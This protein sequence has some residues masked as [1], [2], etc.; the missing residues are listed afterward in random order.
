MPKVT[1][2]PGDGIGPEI[3]QVLL[4]VVEALDI[5]IEW[6]IFDAGHKVYHTLGILI[7]EAAYESIK[8]NKVAIKGPIT[9]PIGSGFRSIN[10]DLRK[11]FDLF[12][13]LRPVQN[14]GTVPSRYQNIDIVLFRENTEDLYMGLEEKISDD[15]ARSIKVITRKASERIAQAAFEYARQHNRKKVTVVS[16]ANIMKLSDGLFLNS[17]RSIAQAYPEIKFEEILVDNMA[18]QLVLKPEQFDVVVTENL[19]GDILSDLMAGLVGGLGFVPGANLGE[20]IAV[21][22][23]VHGSALDI[24]GQNKANPSALLLSCALMLDHLGFKEEAALIRL[25]IHQFYLDERNYT[26]DLGGSVGTVE[27]QKRIIKII[28]SNKEIPND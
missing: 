12:A 6:E 2:I 16:K 21:F 24:A 20:D 18:M 26:Y 3:T 8:R 14:I 15:E 28:L 23:S 22:E 5:P 17:V 10:V 1:L 13:N 27:Y 7:P 19:Y 11:R 25:S 4:A 9:T